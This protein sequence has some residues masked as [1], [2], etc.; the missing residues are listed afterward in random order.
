[1]LARLLGAILND[2]SNA[3]A[4]AIYFAPSNTETRIAI[5]SAALRMKLGGLPHFSE[6]ESAWTRFINSLNRRKQVRNK[7]AHGAIVTIAMKGK[8]HVRLT[9]PMFDFFRNYPRAKGQ[10]PGLSGHD[11]DAAAK[12]V[13]ALVKQLDIWSQI[14]VTG[15]ATLLEKFGEPPLNPSIEDPQ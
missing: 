3:M 14:A 10:I 15:D 4:S 1:M 13:F 12:E 11:I 8:N 2:P 7:V 9:A 6:I 5:V